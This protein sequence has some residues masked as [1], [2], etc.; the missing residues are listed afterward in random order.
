MKELPSLAERI[1]SPYDPEAHFS[2]K[3]SV[4]WTGYQ[5]H[6][7]ETYEEDA[8][9]LI[10][11]AETCHSMVPDVA[12]TAGIHHKL[13]EKQLLPAEHIIEAGYH[14]A[15]L[16]VS[17]AQ[18]YG[19]ALIGPVRGNASWQAPANQGYDLTHFQ[20]HW[21]EQR[22]ICPPGKV[23]TKWRPGEDAFGNPIIALKFSR[24]DGKPCPVRSLCTRGETAPRH[25][26]LHPREQHDA[27]QAARERITSAE[28]KAPYKV[29]AGVEGTLSQGIRAF[30]LRRTRYRGLAKT[31]LQH[32][33]TAAAMNIKRA[34][35][36][37]D[38]VGQAKTR[39]S[40]LAALAA[41]A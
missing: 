25:I 17:S 18:P 16:L 36:W 7:T 10:V 28:G 24:S 6:L 12:R 39:V 32:V 20:I 19:M 4:T 41:A 14:D 33:A 29:R 21:D 38:G 35:N 26:V 11:P 40:R 13:S 30:G 27:L 8:A 2:D 22:V 1:C 15:A 5:V 3:R 9:H 31:S 23:S 34:V 37:L